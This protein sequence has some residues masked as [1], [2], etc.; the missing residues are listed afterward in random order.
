MSKQKNV[1][2]DSLFG[3]ASLARSTPETRG[4]AAVAYGLGALAIETG[5]RA[6]E[7]PS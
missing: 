7:S 5:S 3:T 6:R 4:H 1:A 2:L